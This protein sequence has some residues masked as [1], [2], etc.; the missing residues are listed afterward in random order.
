MIA[1][2]MIRFQ[3]LLYGLRAQQNVAMTTRMPNSLAFSLFLP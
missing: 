3:V 2:C 1:M